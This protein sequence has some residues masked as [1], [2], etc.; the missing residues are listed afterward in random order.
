MKRRLHSPEQVVQKLRDADTKIASGATV[1]QV[2][3]EMGISD[4]TY[5][6]WRRQYGQMKLDG[7]DDYIEM[8][9]YKGVTGT[10]PRTMAAWVK[11]TSSRGEIMSWGSDEYGRM[12]I[13]S[14]IRE[15][16]G[17]TPKGGYLYINDAIHDDKW[18]HVVAVVKEA[19]LPNY[20]SK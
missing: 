13:F 11:T 15:R 20:P 2:C 3:K 7:N 1:E 19:E 18:H 8:T 12:W 10:R 9:K 4:A 17:V 6:N 16:I 5:Y 14:F